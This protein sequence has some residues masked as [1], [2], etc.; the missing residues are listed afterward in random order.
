MIEPADYH[1]LMDVIGSMRADD[2]REIECQYVEI[3]GYELTHRCLAGDAWVAV[4]EGEPVAAFGVQPI[5]ASTLQIWAFGTDDMKRAVPAMSRFIM[6][7]CLMRWIE[8][9]FTRVEAR[10]IA[11]HETAHRWMGSLGGVPSP[12]KAFGKN[13]EDFVMFAWAP[14][15]MDMVRD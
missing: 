7:P 12:C 15:T 3:S 1:S 6:G 10:S 8:D 14:L 11:D 13:G 2:R 4:I 9:G 5:A